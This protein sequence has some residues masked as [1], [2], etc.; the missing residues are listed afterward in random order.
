MLGKYK[1]RPTNIEGLRT[2]PPEQSMESVEFR[3][4]NGRLASTWVNPD[5]PNQCL[6]AKENPHLLK[7]VCQSWRNELFNGLIPKAS[8]QDMVESLFGQLRTNTSNNESVGA[9]S[10]A[11][12]LLI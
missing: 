8:N 9:R 6:L 10:S 5:A 2:F 3:T 1:S 4:V 11:P 12:V 7:R